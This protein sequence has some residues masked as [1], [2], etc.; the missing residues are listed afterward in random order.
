MQIEFEGGAV[1]PK[2]VM[3]PRQAVVFYGEGK[4]IH[5]A[6][7]HEM[8]M[9]GGRPVAG[10]GR[11]ITL[12][13][14]KALAACANET[15]R[16][17]PEIMPGHVLLASDELLAWWRPAGVA[18]MSFDI[19]WHNGEEGRDR[20][21]G[22]FLKMALPAL[23]FI[24]RRCSM[25][26]QAFQGIYVYALEKNQRPEGSSTMFRA[27][28]LNVNDNGSVCWG[29]SSKPNGR[30]VNDIP[31]WESLFFSSKF[32]HYNQSSPVRSRTPYKWLADYAAAGDTE[33]PVTEL[34]P[35][36]KSLNQ[37]VE[38]HY[39]QGVHVA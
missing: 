26:N 8:S 12:P 27:P 3:D 35:M 10:S 15:L 17:T 14:V 19:D 38:W 34:L 20:L 16:R 7:I 18:E 23:V 24:L 33:F 22:A 25:G 36:K 30:R 9:V 32:T 5:M 39:K 29:N 6:T 11:P 31:K 21:Q 28:L 1:I 2:K 13:A 4:A 37:V